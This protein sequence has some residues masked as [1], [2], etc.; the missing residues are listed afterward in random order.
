MAVLYLGE[1]WQPPKEQLVH[2]LCINV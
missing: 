2:L 1:V